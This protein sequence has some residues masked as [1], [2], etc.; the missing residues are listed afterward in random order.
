MRPIPHLVSPQW[1]AS[2]LQAESEAEPRLVIV[3]VRWSLTDAQAGRRA[4]EA[5]HLPGAAFLDLEKTLAAPH[6]AGP[7]RHPIPS[8]EAFAETM[9]AIGVDDDTLVVAYD[10]VGGAHAGRLWFLL[11]YFGHE[12]GAVLDGGLG[13]WTQQGLPLTTSP[14]VRATA[15]GR[16]TARAQ[17]GL[18]VDRQAVR[19]RKSDVVLLDARAAERYRGETEPVDKRPGHIPGAL[20]APFSRNLADGKF[21]PPTKLA[22]HYGGLGI[23]PTTQ[24]IVQC[25]SGVTACHVLLGLELAGLGKNARLYEGSYSDWASSD[26]PVAVGSSPAGDQ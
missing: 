21:L 5:G 13:A 15:A 16:F 2:R 12:T 20:S 23:A 14:F 8:A 19:S 1:L 24:V 3:D 26:E 6:G 25:G 7:G 22:E 4:Y 18:I 10:D 11:R 17:P 9:A